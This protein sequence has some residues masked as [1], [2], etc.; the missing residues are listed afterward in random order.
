MTP[1]RNWANASFDVL[2]VR[3]CVLIPQKL[4]ISDGTPR[5]MEG[6]KKKRNNDKK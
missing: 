3:V 1:D 4:S 5:E 6:T 2:I